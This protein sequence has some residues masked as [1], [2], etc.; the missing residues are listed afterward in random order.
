MDAVGKAKKARRAIV[1]L[2]FGSTGRSMHRTYIDTPGAKP[3]ELLAKL[4]TPDADE[5]SLSPAQRRLL[6]GGSAG[7]CGLTEEAA[8]DAKVAVPADVAMS[9]EEENEAAEPA[10]ATDG[11]AAMNGAE[12]ESVFRLISPCRVVPAQQSCLEYESTSPMVP[13]G[14]L[15]G[16]MVP[17]RG[18][19]LCVRKDEA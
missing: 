13:I 14:L 1:K 7:L 16:K 5:A 6:L 17:K 15:Q 18:V 3:D 4:K 12:A 8:V 19:I 11:D 2:S 9:G 10:A